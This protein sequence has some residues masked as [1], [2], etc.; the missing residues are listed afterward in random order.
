MGFLLEV[1][2]SWMLALSPPDRWSGLQLSDNDSTGGELILGAPAWT[3]DSLSNIIS[4]TFVILGM[5]LNT[6]S[7]LFLFSRSEWGMLSIR[8]EVPESGW[9]I[10]KVEMTDPTLALVAFLT[11]FLAVLLA[12]PDLTRTP[13]TPMGLLEVLTTSGTMSVLGEILVCS[14]WR[15]K[16]PW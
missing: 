10:G 11:V 16:L 5:L 1:S 6:F 14:R 13:L 15:R 8:E 12:W 3:L 4:E 2:L 9:V 7:L